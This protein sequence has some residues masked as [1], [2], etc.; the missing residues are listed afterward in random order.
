MTGN[1]YRIINF[2]SILLMLVAL[3]FLA[4]CVPKG[5]VQI[6]GYPGVANRAPEKTRT[7]ELDA[8]L[9]EAE[10]LCYQGQYKK[11]AAIYKKLLEKY[12]KDPKITP[13]LL[14]RLQK[15]YLSS[16]DYDVSET[17]GKRLLSEY[18]NYYGAPEVHVNLIEAAVEKGELQRALKDGQKLWAF[19]GDTEEKARLA[20]L[21]SRIF[22]KKKDGLDAFYWLVEAERLAAGAELKNRIYSQMTKVVSLLNEHQVKSLL[23]EYRGRFPELWLETR[24]VEIM[25]DNGKLDEAA[26][27]LNYLINSFP[28]HPLAQKFRE[29]REAI[30]QE[31]D[32][33]ADAI[34]CLLPL[35]GRLQPYGRRLLR[36]LYMAQELY[37]LSTWE[38]PIKI[39]VKDSNSEDG[40]ASVVD[41]LVRDHHVLAIMGP[42]SRKVVDEAA[43]EA[44]KLRV[45]IVTLTQKEDVVNIGDYVFRVFLTNREQA[46]LLVSYAVGELGF[47]NFGILYPEDKYGR[48]FEHAF[49]EEM[50]KLPV[51]LMADVGYDPGTTD[52]TRPIR[53]LFVRAGIPLPTK[54]RKEKPISVLSPPVFDAIFLP[55]QVQTASLIAS[56]L[57]YND[58]VGVRLFGTNLWNTPRLE[59]EYA[60]YLEGAIFTGG[61]FAG[62]SNPEV[63]QFVERFEASYDEKP[64]YL[65]AQAYDVLNL[66]LEARKRAERPSRGAIRSQ[67][68]KIRNFEGVTGKMS[69]LPSGNAKKEMFLLTVRGGEI[70]EL[71]VDQE[72]LYLKLG[73]F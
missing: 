12:P 63:Q 47:H 66:I 36:G 48:F 38:Q 9:K 32:V 33:D 18:P 55:D 7:T 35:S 16:G 20:Y 28:M 3:A 27:R 73:N 23:P 34:G 43:L 4:S 15:A 25:I 54:N 69:I 26:G 11:C 62:S 1:I 64:Q 50:K 68:L 10:D 46:R 44:Q 13:L 30:E 53:N 58:V 42:L 19:L 24:L 39:I 2:K 45:P 49:S 72:E 5:L 57:V 65:E 59:K 8:K 61:F 29:L 21:L 71:N 17:Y 22:T 60:P 41:E 40:I 51:K 31:R 67:L 70:R 14:S 37:N 52:F 6:P 56:Q